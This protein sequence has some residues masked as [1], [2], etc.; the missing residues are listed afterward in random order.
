MCPV[1]Q[2]LPST[3]VD[4]TNY[5]SLL[6]KS[7]RSRDLF[8]DGN[9]FMDET[10]GTVELIPNWEL[11]YLSNGAENML[12]KAG[13]TLSAIEAFVLDSTGAR[14]LRIGGFKGIRTDRRTSSIIELDG[15]SSNGT[16]PLSPSREG[17]VVKLQ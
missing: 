7:S 17:E 4:L 1:T 8:P 5:Q 14:L 13:I 3:P 15:V 11:P 10:T 16:I 2:E 6:V 9:V 12:G